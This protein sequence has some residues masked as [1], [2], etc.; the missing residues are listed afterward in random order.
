LNGRKRDMERSPEIEELVAAW[1]ASATTGDPSLVATRVSQDDATRLIGSDPTEFF[2]GGAAVSE[3]LNGELVGAAGNVTFTPSNTEAFA[4]GSVG[5][6][7]SHITI[8]M[9]D[10]RRVTPR[11]SAV[12][13]QD[14]GVWVFVQIHA[15]IGVTNDAVGWVYPE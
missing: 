7:T 12:F 6:A 4:E 9:P 11:W 15:S 14:N 1:F 10:G 3:F 8:T 2:K 5:W 13:H